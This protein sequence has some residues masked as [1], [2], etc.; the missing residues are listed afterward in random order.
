MESATRTLRAA[1]VQMESENGRIEANLERAGRFVDDAAQRGAKLIVLPEFMATGYIFT[2][3]IWDG[4]EPGEGP[5]VRWL[6]K[7]SKRLGVWLAAGFLEADGEDFY[8]TF[9]VTNPDGDEG[10]RVRKQTPAAAEA[11]FTKGEAGPHVIDTDLGRL[12]IGICYENQL[13]YM[14]RLMC[15]QSVD[16]MLMPHSAPTITPRPW[17]IGKTIGRFESILKNLARVYASSLGIPVIMVNKSGRWR[18]PIPLLP[19]FDQDSRFPGFSAIVDSNGE[20]KAQ[21]GDEEGLIVEDVILDPSRKTNSWPGCHGRWSMKEPL[22]LNAFRLMEAAG[23][24]WYAL[25]RERRRR[26]AEISLPG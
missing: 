1:A 25:S 2:E 8:N 20:V 10:G 23:R 16:L 6:R 11:F 4:G 3:A 13:A 22:A 21:L 26:A 24:A 19:F 14:P 17:F 9:V 18:S 7:N 5:T 15:S 12:G